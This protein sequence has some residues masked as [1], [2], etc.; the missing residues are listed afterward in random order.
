MFILTPSLNNYFL[1]LTYFIN[2]ASKGFDIIYLGCY[3][4]N[5]NLVKIV[6]ISSA[7]NVKLYASKTQFDPLTHFCF[8]L[9]NLK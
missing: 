9:F 2:F 7:R 1:A 3:P 6:D 8:A 5:E 4:E